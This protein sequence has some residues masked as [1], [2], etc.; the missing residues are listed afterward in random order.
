[1]EVSHSLSTQ[2]YFDSLALF[3][4]I[5]LTRLDFTLI[6]PVKQLQNASSIL[7]QPRLFCK[8]RLDF[9]GPF[10]S[11]GEIKKKKI[12]VNVGTAYTMG[13]NNRSVSCL[14]TLLHFQI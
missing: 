14:T 1:M 7:N 6:T 8:N 10:G 2:Y 12:G 3:T 4:L 13:L 5:A 11:L 9:I